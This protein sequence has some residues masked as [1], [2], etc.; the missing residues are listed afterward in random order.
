MYLRWDSFVP[1]VY[2]RSLVF[3]LISRCWRICSSYENFHNEMLFL[4]NVLACNGYPI[5]F[6]DSCLNTFVNRKHTVS[7]SETVFGPEKKLV[8]LCLPYTGIDCEK[9]KRQL[10]R[11]LSVVA[12][13]IK[14]QVVYKAALKLSTLS[15]LKDQIPLL[16]NSHVVYRVDCKNCKEFYVGM[17]CRR[18][19]QRMKE[20]SQSDNSAIY[21]HC[22]ECRH[23]ADFEMPQILAR[24]NCQSRLYTKEALLIR[25]L[26]AYLTLN[27]N[28]GSTELKL[29]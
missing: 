15:R 18:L 8:M 6:F 14:L 10:T 1:K 12:P 13:W 29:W 28:T 2:K 11:M 26:Q 4:K 23:L 19:E 21:K 20:H 25:D 17:T 3:G 27:Q 9:L 16:S 7:N 5:T 22:E 24:D